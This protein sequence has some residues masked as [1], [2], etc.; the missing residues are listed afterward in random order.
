[1]PSVKK[2]VFKRARGGSSTSRIAKRPMTNPRISMDLKYVDTD[3]TTQTAGSVAGTLVPLTAID[4]DVSQN[5]RIGAQV[6]LKSL[7]CRWIVSSRD[8]GNGGSLAGSFS[9]YRIIFF[10]W[11]PATTPIASDIVSGSDA[12]VDTRRY[13]QDNAQSYSILFD[14][15]TIVAK[16]QASASAPLYNNQSTDGPYAK[17]FTIPRK[18][19][20]FLTAVGVTSGTNKV[21]AL[22]LSATDTALDKPALHLKTRAF[23]HG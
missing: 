17:E 23:F 1:M 10:Q 14:R 8:G 3:V 9:G 2:Q 16:S 15:S 5:G 21:Y 7:Q 12:F 19:S 13:N 20:R 11:H 18:A 22:L 4:Q 6:S